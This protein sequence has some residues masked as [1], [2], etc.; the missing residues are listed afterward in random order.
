[1]ETYQIAIYMRLSKEDNKEQESNSITTQRILLQKFV[2]EHFSNYQIME[3]C[4]DGY[5]GTNF[6]RPEIQKLLQMAK[7]L[8]INCIIVKDFS[9]F[10]RDYIELGSYLEQIFPFLGVRFISI[11]DNYDSEKYHGTL[12]DIDINFKNL[13][14]DLYSKDLSQKV[15]TALSV[16]K[17]SEQYVSSNSPFG[18][19][20][21]PKDRHQLKI[22]KEEAVVVKRIFDLT[23]QGYTSG[24]IAKLLKEGIKTPIEFKIAKGATSRI[25]KGERFFWT[26]STICSILSNQIYIGHIVQKNTQKIL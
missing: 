26:K 19:E 9:R 5:T 18:Y 20:K 21:D 7:E 4:D 22:V 12:A 6:E 17:E 8:K 25:P 24:K 14:Y 15:K 11:N 1:M 2:A 16:K 3:F 10:A 23:M 13:L